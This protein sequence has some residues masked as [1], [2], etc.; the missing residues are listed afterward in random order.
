[1]QVRNS[2]SSQSII[3]ASFS[4]HARS[5]KT[6]ETIQE[7]Q[8]NEDTSALLDSM[9]ATQPAATDSSV[10]DTSSSTESQDFLDSL[11][12]WQPSP[13]F[14]TIDGAVQM[15][16]WIGSGGT[17]AV[18]QY[19]DTAIKCYDDDSEEETPGRNQKLFANECA[20]MT[21][22][23][24][25]K[26]PHMVQFNGILDSKPC[27]LMMRFLPKTLTKLLQE[28]PALEWCDR[29]QLAIELVEF[30]QFAHK[31]G[32]IH[33]S[34]KSDNILVDNENHIYVAD[35]GTAIDKSNPTP[36]I[37]RGF[38]PTHSAP[39]VLRHPTKRTEKCDIY[40]LG[41]V[42]WQIAH[43]GEKIYNGY[44]SVQIFHG[45]IYGAR[46][47]IAH[48]CPPIFKSIIQRCWKFK[49]KERPQAKTILNFLTA[50]LNSLNAEEE[51][52][53]QPTRRP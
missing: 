49:P 40:S 39:E 47:E 29:Y 32:I 22:L 44:D 15:C 46:P 23:S 36:D 34:I 11:L 5:E 3:L 24:A 50:G 12:S 17:A 25:L 31:N 2:T 18:Y 6:V 7:Q 26:A 27:S 42:L 16:N 30:L 19:K 52:L 38:L 28:T 13:L 9:V 53:R 14:T 20:I 43:P 10:I 4:A 41:I 1:M 21:K 48:D 33:G 8:V 51:M 35:F 37:K 45:V